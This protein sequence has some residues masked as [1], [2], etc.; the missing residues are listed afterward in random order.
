MKMKPIKRKTDPEKTRKEPCH[1]A[2]GE[3]YQDIKNRA[4]SVIKTW[5]ELMEGYL[6]SDEREEAPE[7]AD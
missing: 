1:Q 3:S 6:D 2:A 4:P 7:Q 5:Q